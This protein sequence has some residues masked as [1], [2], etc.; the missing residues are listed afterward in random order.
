[1][2]LAWEVLGDPG[3]KQTYDLQQAPSRQYSA[4]NTWSRAPRPSWG[5]TRRS[6]STAGTSSGYESVRK[7]TFR[8]I[9]TCGCRGYPFTHVSWR[10]D[11]SEYSTCP[12]RKLRKRCGFYY[13]DSGAYVSWDGAK[14]ARWTRRNEARK[15]PEAAKKAKQAKD[16]AS[17]QARREAAQAEREA[18]QRREE[19][20]RIRNREAPLS[21]AEARRRGLSY[22]RGKPYKYG[23]DSMRD[24]NSNCLR[25]RE[26]ERLKRA[27]QKLAE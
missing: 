2:R 23:H 14:T 24:L 26:L 21:P 11:F 6:A 10:I 16:R 1:M 19:E 15:D 17:S 9:C 20:V 3:K 22:Y 12:A 18:N 27:S 13:S 25:C 4:T 5:S 7:T 8:E